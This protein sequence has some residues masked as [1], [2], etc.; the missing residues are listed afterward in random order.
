M[1]ALTSAAARS[2]SIVS[3]YGN[4]A[5]ISDCHG[6]SG[7]NEWPR[8][9]ARD[10][11]SA[12]SSSAR[13]STALRTRC[14]ARSHSVPPSLRQRRALAAG[15]AA[16]P[17]DL[18]DRDEDAVAAG[19]R[20]L[21]VVAVLPSAAAPEHLLVARHAVV[22]VDDQVAR[23]QALEDVAR[24]DPSKR[25]RAAHPDRPEQLAIGDEG[26]AVRATGEAAVEAPV[27]ERD[28]AGGRR[29]PH[30]LDDRDRLPGLGEQVGQPR[31]LV[32]GEH[33]PGA[34]GSPRGDRIDQAPGPAGWQDRLAPAERVAGRQPAPRHRDALGWL[35]FPGQL[36][37]PRRDQPALPVARAEVRRGPVL[38]QLAGLDQ[39]APSLVGLAPQE[40]GGLGEVTRL[41]EDQQRAGGDVVEPGRRREVG[42]PD[43]GRVADRERPGRRCV[44]R[45]RRGGPPALVRVGLEPVEV[46]RETLGEARR[47]PAQPVADGRRP[48]GRE[49]ELGRGQEQR[50][51]DR[52]DR[53]LVGRVERAQR[54]DLVAEELDPDRQRHRRREDVDDPAATGEFAPAGHLRDRHVAEAE[55]LVEQPVLVDP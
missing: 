52:P 33:D 30:P 11:Y 43:L 6:L 10:A 1:S 8:A 44:L 24:H 37:R 47:G 13:S 20:Q 55:Q 39:L 16:D 2:W 40:L 35:R 38:G 21:E 5:S 27:D 54:V 28:R 49:Q 26:Q 48:A 36:E 3:S 12:S 53:A 9:S 42:R 4:D 25:P 46:G 15:I 23:R 51:L 45:A 29:L 31:C 14:L 41:V 7:A 19:E 22:D 34:V 18:L 17:R 50:P 32:G